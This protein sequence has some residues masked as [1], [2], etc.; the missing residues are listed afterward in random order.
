MNSININY[1][2]HTIEITKNFEKKARMFGTEEYNEL[3]NARKEFPTYRLSIKANKSSNTFKGMDYDFMSD[4]IKKHDNE[5][6]THLAEFEKLRKNKLSYGE[7]KQWFVE[8][9]TV[10]KDCKTKAEWVLAA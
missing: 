3:C 1:R 10:F 7:I 5:E 4:Y 2:N 8:T 6:K 9:Y